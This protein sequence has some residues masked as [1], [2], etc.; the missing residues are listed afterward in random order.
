MTHLIKIMKINEVGVLLIGESADTQLISL[1]REL[2]KSG[3]TPFWLH[4]NPIE[5]LLPNVVI[6]PNVPDFTVDPMVGDQYSCNQIDWVIIR[7]LPEL[8]KDMPTDEWR[9]SI[10]GVIEILISEGVNFIPGK[11]D[12]ITKANNKISIQ[13]TMIECGFQVPPSIVTNINNSI[14]RTLSHDVVL[15]P[16]RNHRKGSGSLS[17]TI[18]VNRTN[19]DGVLK[20]FGDQFRG[21][22]P[23]LIQETIFG[24][25]IRSLV[26]KKFHFSIS[27]TSGTQHIDSRY[28]DFSK[29]RASFFDLPDHIVEMCR[30]LLFRLGLNVAVFDFIKNEKQYFLLDLNPTGLFSGFETLLESNIMSKNYASLVEGIRKSNESSVDQNDSIFE[31]SYSCPEREKRELFGIAAASKIDSK[32]SE[33]FCFEHGKLYS[34]KMDVLT[35]EDLTLDLLNNFCNFMTKLNQEGWYHGDIRPEHLRVHSGNKI[36]LIDWER[37]CSF[38]FKQQFWNSPPIRG[39][40][41][42]AH[43]KTLTSPQKYDESTEVFSFLIS[44][45]E[46]ANG[47]KFRDPSNFSNAQDFFEY[48]CTAAEIKD[49]QLDEESDLSYIFNHNPKSWNELSAIIIQL[50]ESRTMN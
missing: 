11:P 21:S 46:L 7:G 24:E 34:E 42:Y 39:H 1:E 47:R 36:I 28:Y 50:I 19:L 30:L 22:S 15:K 44:L 49:L 37:C 25:N 32:Y 14:A 10:D 8:G 29:M 18:Y 9:K 45:L 31:K 41:G 33:I 43:P 35:I 13:R 6:F 38:D 12:S 17:K 3:K 20:K 23:V 26:S 5:G 40:W 27:Y 48:C 2:R 4:I 16:M